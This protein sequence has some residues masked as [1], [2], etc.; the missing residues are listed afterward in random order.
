MTIFAVT[1]RGDAAGPLLLLW[2]DDADEAIATIEAQE[3]IGALFERGYDDSPGGY[4]IAVADE[5][6]KALWATSVRQGID[7]GMIHPG[8]DDPDWLTFLRPPEFEPVIE[9]D[10]DE[11]PPPAG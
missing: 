7:E 1:R 8:T 9:D 2:A 5:Q 10:D 11:T 3:D 6:Q 4:E